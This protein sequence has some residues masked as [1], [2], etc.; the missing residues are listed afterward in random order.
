M[1]NLKDITLHKLDVKISPCHDCL[2]YTQVYSTPF[3][4]DSIYL[5]F[6][7]L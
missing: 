3:I 1:E 6:A 2:C 5:S 4:Y 7:L